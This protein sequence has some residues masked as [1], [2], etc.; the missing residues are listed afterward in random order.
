MLAVFA[1]ASGSARLVVFAACSVVLA[2]IW[3]V[4]IQLVVLRAVC[5]WCMADHATGLLFGV[6]A[7][8]AVHPSQIFRI[9]T[10]AAMAGVAALLL[11]QFAVPY[12]PGRPAFLASAGGG[13]GVIE[14]GAIRFSSSDTP[15]LGAAEGRATIVLLADYACPH[16][17]AT[18]GYLMQFLAAD[19]KRFQI[20]VA[21]VPMNHDCNRTLVSTEPRFEHS[22]ELA[23]LALAVWTTHPSRF[24]AFD[25]WL[26]DSEMPR[27]PNEARAE[28]ERLVGRD[29]L[30]AALKEPA[31]SA[32]IARNVDAF[33]AAKAKRLPVLLRNNGP[34]IEG[35][36][37]SA[38]EFD[39]LLT[40]SGRP[41]QLER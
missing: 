30:G 10:I 26:F 38:E 11:G 35:E 4:A 9:P 24:A 41:S 37:N 22:C 17:R 32:A 31:V 27:P 5:P 36:P 28:A 34:S 23:T 1:V 25:T 33:E 14:V 16:C 20:L 29:A 19:P 21:P 39:L 7:W 3:F 15:S 18:H 12:K 40:D 13:D 2:A 6:L 8:R